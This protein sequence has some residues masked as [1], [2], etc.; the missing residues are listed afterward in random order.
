MGFVVPFDLRIRRILLPALYVSGFWIHQ[1][2]NLEA[3]YLTS[4]DLDLGDAMC[5][6]QGDTNLRRSRTFLCELAN[7]VDNLFRGDLE[8]SWGRT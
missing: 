3:S 4:D 5:I 2:S 7:L 8:P 1:V 6:S